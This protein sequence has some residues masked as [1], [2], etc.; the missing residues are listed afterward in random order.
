MRLRLTK[1]VQVPR[2]RSLRIQDDPLALL[3]DPD[4]GSLD[5]RLVTEQRTERGF[6]H[7]ASTGEDEDGDEEGGKTI[8]AGDDTGDD[9]GTEEHMGK[10]TGN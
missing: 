4:D 10:E 2:H 9:G 1:Y 5:R 8:S 3:G 7:T 6:D